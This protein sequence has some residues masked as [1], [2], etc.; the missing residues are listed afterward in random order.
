[1]SPGAG[2]PEDRR[3]VSEGEALM[4]PKRSKIITR[5]QLAWLRF[6]SAFA[7]LLEAVEELVEVSHENRI[8]DV[9]AAVLSARAR[10]ASARR[11]KR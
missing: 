8:A 2:R 11:G 7:A 5:E 6:Q 3:A 4:A 10:K 1:M 9:G